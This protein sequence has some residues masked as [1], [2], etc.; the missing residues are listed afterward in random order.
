V[1]LRDRS[2][3]AGRIEKAVL[4]ALFPNKSKG[5]DTLELGQSWRFNNVHSAVTNGVKLS[6]QRDRWWA[7][8]PVSGQGWLDIDAIIKGFVTVVMI[9]VGGAIAMV[10]GGT[11]GVG[12]V[13]VA[14]GTAPLLISAFITWLVVRAKR[15]KGQ[16]SGVGRALT[17][18]VV[19]FRT[20][21]ATAEAEQLRFEEG[22][23]IFSKYLPWAISFGLTERWT[24][25][26]QRLVD[27]GRLPAEAPAW[28]AGASW[29]LSQLSGQLNDFG[30]S[31]D[32]A[33]TPVS[34]GSSSSYSSSDSGFGSSSSAFD[35]GGGFSGG[36]GGGGDMGSW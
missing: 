4:R 5:N 8:E 2:L 1:E 10:F 17:D 28:Y 9:I 6:S 11:F 36:G 31:V 16:R 20:Y 18:Q 22:E 33:S 24:Q 25:V 3:A 34:S 27:L 29:D 32:A 35:S 23:D 19:G 7:R 26:C 13:L 21:L 30:S 14:L 12:L 15:A